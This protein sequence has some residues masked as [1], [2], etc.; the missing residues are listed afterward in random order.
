MVH[1]WTHAARLALPEYSFSIN[2][3]ILVHSEERSNRYTWAI[4]FMAP[5]TLTVSRK[6][7]VPHT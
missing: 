1:K 4:A 2:K 7:Y 6:Y 5:R 3:N